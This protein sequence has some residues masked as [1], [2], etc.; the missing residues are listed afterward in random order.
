MAMKFFEAI[1]AHMEWAD[2][3][4][5]AA[6][7]EAQDGATDEP[8]RDTLLHMHL[9]QRGFLWRWAEAFASPVDPQDLQPE[10]NPHDFQ[11]ATELRDWAQSYY[12]LVLEFLKNL[13]ASELDGVVEFPSAPELE[14]E[15][16][17]P[18]DPVTLRDTLYQVVAH[19]THHRGQLNRRIR[20][21]D[22]EPPTVDYLLWVW[23]DR[24][25][26]VW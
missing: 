7:L 13:D 20:E 3:M 5:W 6:T 25:A 17:K 12:P 1:Y 11:S 8:L 9:V 2:S 18:P 19:S 24:P 26:P 16:G 21:L 22:G 15:L 4:V 10:V 23:K 14:E